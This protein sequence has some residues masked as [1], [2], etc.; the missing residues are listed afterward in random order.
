MP[1][2]GREGL[3]GVCSAGLSVYIDMFVG[4]GYRSVWLK[5]GGTTRG[6]W[7]ETGENGLLVF[8]LKRLLGGPEVSW[9]LGG[10][11]CVYISFRLRYCKGD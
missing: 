7:E 8:V 1:F 4:G 6:S 2:W 9:G 5:L 3:E 11:M 10:Y